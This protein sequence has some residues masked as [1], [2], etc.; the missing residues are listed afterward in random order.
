MIRY[1]A[2]HLII[3]FFY[4]VTVLSLWYRILYLIY[5]YYYSLSR[6]LLFPYSHF[7]PSFSGSQKLYNSTTKRTRDTCRTLTQI[8][9]T[10]TE[11][12]Y[13]GL[14]EARATERERKRR[15]ERAAATHGTI[16]L[17]CT[18]IIQLALYLSFGHRKAE[19][20]LVRSIP[21]FERLPKC[22]PSYRRHLNSILR[23]L[24]T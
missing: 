16:S 15:T 6:L 18:S 23:N 8:Q 22:K 24:T 17:L 14:E 19:N 9:N 2:Q 3:H 4:P 5:D 1:G 7:V 21:S 10:N 20:I 13:D 12:Q 11:K